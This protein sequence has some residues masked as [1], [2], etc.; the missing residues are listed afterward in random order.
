MLH[1][2]NDQ[3][4]NKPQLLGFMDSTSIELQTDAAVRFRDSQWKTR[5]LVLGLAVLI[6]CRSTTLLDRQWLA[7]LPWWLWA[8]VFGLIPQAFLLLF[9]IITRI[10][11]GRFF[12]P[13]LR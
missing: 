10:P 2:D 11:R 7:Q 9:P 4:C 13:T 12:I 1:C 5:W 3:Q 6:L 8:V